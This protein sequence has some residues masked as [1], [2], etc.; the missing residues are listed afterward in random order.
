MDLHRPFTIITPTADGDALSVLAGADRA[1]TA[2]EVQRLAGR[3][4]IQG[5]RQALKRLEEQGIVTATRAGNAVLFGLNR[6]HLGA[7]AVIQLASIRD[8]LINR[9]QEQL[10]GWGLACEHASLF[11]SAATGGMRPASDIDLLIVRADSLDP[12][13]PSWREQLG[14]LTRSVAGWTGND[15]QVVELSQSAVVAQIDDPD[16]FLRDVERDGIWL[17]GQASYLL[18]ARS[19]LVRS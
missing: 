4:S 18:L 17:A 10:A 12:D 19:G 13:E 2:S 9:M 1:F 8:E 11:G 7:A 5:I 15:P 14:N 3:R 16:S 6:E